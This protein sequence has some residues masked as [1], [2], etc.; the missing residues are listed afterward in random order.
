MPC[1]ATI[2]W[3]KSIKQRTRSGLSVYEHSMLR[4]ACA[5]VLHALSLAPACRRFVELSFERVGL[6]IRWE[7]PTGVDEV[8]VLAQGPCEGRILVTIRADFFR[9][10]EVSLLLTRIIPM[11]PS[12]AVHFACVPA[13]LPPFPRQTISARAC[14]SSNISC[15]AA[16]VS[17]TELMDGC[18]QGTL[19]G[20]PSKAFTELGWRPYVTVR[21]LV[22]EM[23]DADMAL[24]M[25]A[26]AQ[27]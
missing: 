4:E 18:A 13:V 11:L 6:P 20:N 10:V 8:G 25:E 22:N 3:A 21:Q 9:P 1:Q 17:K 12:W 27:H 19:S 15:T 7:G 14:I 16:C 5:A 24:A 23:V 26:Q 2:A